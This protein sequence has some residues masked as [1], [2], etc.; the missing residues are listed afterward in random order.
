MIKKLLFPLF[1][2]LVHTVVLGAN[3]SSTASG[4]NW[5]DR[6]TWV[7]GVVPTSS[8]NVT[9]VSGSNITLDTNINIGNATYT[10]NGNVTDNGSHT[11]TATASS[12]KLIISSNSITTFGGSASWNGSTITINTGSS[13]IVGAL[14]IGNGT[15][16][17]IGGSLIVN[18]NVDDN[19]N[20]SGGFTVTGYVQVYGDYT[21]PVGGVSV[22]G[23]GVFQTSGSINTTG[24]STV[25]GSPNNCTT[26]PCS[27][28]SISCGDGTNS[29]SS[30]VSPTNQVLCSGQTISPISFVSG[31]TVTS[32]QWQSSTT[33]GG[34]GFTNIGDANNNNYI[35]P[36]PSVT[37]WYRMKY[38]TSSCPDLISPSSKISLNNNTAP[39]AGTI[40]GGNRSYC[41]NSNSTTMTLS[42]YTATGFQWQ[43]SSDNSTFANISSATSASYTATNVSS[44]TYYRVVVSNGS[45]N[46]VNSASVVITKISTTVGTPTAITISAGTEPSCQLIN[47]TTTTTYATTATSNIGFNWSLS[48]S[49]AGVMNATTGVMTWAN[50]F[51]GT[52]NIQVTASGCSSTSSQVT[53]T[54][55]IT[56]TVTINPFSP[57]TTTRCQGAGIVTTTTTANNSTGITYSLDATTAAFLGNSINPSTAAVTYAAGWR[58]TTTI[59]ASAAGCNGPATTTVTV[60]VNPL[61]DNTASTGFTGGSFCIGSQATI[62][63]D[64]NNGSGVLPYNLVY[65]NDI[66]S[67]TS[68]VTITT[69]SPTAFNLSPNPTTTTTYTLLSITDANGCVNLSP[70][71]F[72]AK[73]TILSLPSSPTIGT[74]TQPTCA[75]ATGT[76]TVTAPTGMNYSIDG[77]TYTN[78]SGIF[79]AVAAGS[80][81]V[82]AKNSSG[83]ISAVTNVTI[84]S[85]AK[86]WN[87][88]SSIDWNTAA[89][90][91]PNGVPISSN[92]VIIPN[93][94]NF[95]IISGTNFVAF[96]NTLT[97]SN[98][99]SLVVNP[100]NTI[101]VTD[102]VNV[103]LG[104]FLTFENNASL[105]QINDAAVNTGK[106][107]YKRTTTVMANNYDFQYW[108]SPVVD[109]TLG[110]IWMA[111]T[112]PDTFYNFDSQTTDNWVR[113]V[114]GDIMIPGKGY[115]TRARNGQSGIDYNNVSSIF[116]LGGT[117]TA[118]FYGVPN[119][120]IVYATNIIS[121]NNCVLGNPYPSAIDADKFL[122]ANA[123]LDGTIY[124]WTHNTKIANNAYTSDDYAAYNGVGGVAAVKSISPGPN[125]NIPSGKIAAGQAFLATAKSSSNV[126]FNNS[127][128]LDNSGNRLDNSQFF[129]IKANS[130]TTNTIEKNRIWLNLTNTQGVFKQT[131]VG[132]V[133]NATNGYDSSFDG[134]SF[135]GNDFA[136]FYSINEDKNLT[137][138]GRALPFEKNDAIPLGYSSTIKGVFSIA[139]D[140]V[141]GV[142]VSQDVFI[143]DKSTNTIQNLK[144]GP[145]SFSTE[146][147]T[148]KNRFVLRYINTSKTLRTGTFEAAENTVLVSNT[149]KQIKINSSDEIIN[150]IQVFDM[151]GKSIY[152]KS[153]VNSSEFVITNL[154]MDLQIVLVKI[155][156]QNG[157]TMTKKIV[158]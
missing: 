55:T 121:G 10:F 73:T 9:V 122:N 145:Y 155:V 130:K 86:T 43:S 133:S 28:G 37:T 87:G 139:I 135:D 108:G 105:V 91:T 47:G 53:R 31:T 151:L 36:M 46:V 41:L 54:V 60:T 25:G 79:T 34:T 56:Q 88:S 45:C 69:D 148:F 44:T 143:E 142:L 51:S 68:T 2:L 75:V 134:E 115:I 23:A 136:D 95:P 58:G 102:F 82:T 116:T 128:R 16:I 94:P 96:A 98:G 158:N 90:W 65:K 5:S 127:V 17:S 111:S 57:T 99:G 35:P 103:N 7:G 152:Q 71:N 13:L 48:N 72:T 33:T 138:Q 29:Y 15:T 104:G 6:T 92:C 24:G 120:G 154:A 27:S 129:K 101:T 49:L 89:N 119:N 66:N 84:I 153:D 106:I 83:C 4:G 50:G 67:A 64:A 70:A 132:Y 156:L 117:W 12:G 97:I 141:D 118:K 112:W 14:T 63:F 137:I 144:Q 107:V 147:G 1:L 123:G 19:N 131:L 150:K 77:S 11:L 42:G 74:V 149:N 40:A 39:V 85:A 52:V 76:I 62:T 18:G 61:P 124:F 38:S 81:S 20:G 140:Q 100:T 157:T 93:V 30:A 125:Q 110:A 113:N 146:V 59:K 109:Q 8:D 26:G 22:S 3:I 32:Y 114:A 21:A 78:T 126:V 80:Y